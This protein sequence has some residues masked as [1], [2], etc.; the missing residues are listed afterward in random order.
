MRAAEKTRDRHPKDRTRNKKK[1]P[2]FRK[3]RASYEY[4]SRTPAKSMQNCISF[5]PS[6]ARCIPRL[7]G[8]RYTVQ[9]FGR[10]CRRH[11][12]DR[13]ISGV[14]KR[15]RA[16][17]P[18]PLI[19]T[20]SQRLLTARD[21]PRPP[22]SMPGCY[23]SVLF[24]PV[25]QSASTPAKAESH[26]GL[27]FQT[28]KLAPVQ[29]QI[30]LRQ[31]GQTGERSKLC[32]RGQLAFNPATVEIPCASNARNRSS[33]RSCSMRRPGSSVCRRSSSR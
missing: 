2:G 22:P 18:T 20:R 1:P 8:E 7:R 5:S 29:R 32:G 33:I 23:D 28:A 16:A 19:R 17:G 3:R 25:Q 15:R 21:R 11:V 26:S 9:H 31:T 4:R 10:A 12:R 27:L 14:V 13:T 30:L 24:E 6:F